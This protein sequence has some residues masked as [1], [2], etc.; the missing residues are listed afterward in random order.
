MTTEHKTGEQP[1]NLVLKARDVHFDWTALPLHW[2]PGEPF[3]THTINVMHLLLPEGE[4]WFVRV[5]QQALPLI[6]DEQLREQVIGFIGQEAV[7]AESHQGAQEH[8]REQ[9]IDP[10][11]YVRQIEWTFHRIL[12]DREL[13]TA[14]QRSW[15][16][17]RLAII[18][19]VE[20][21]TAFLGQWV[22]D[23]HGLDRA[24]ADPTMMDL[25]RWHGAEEVEHRS[26][27]FD[28][29][30]HVNGSYLR[31]LRAMVLVA[32]MLVH[33]WARGVKFLMHADPE[34]RGKVKP[35]WRDGSAAARK[36]LLPSYFSLL[37]KLSTFLSRRYH[38]SQ[39]GSTAQAVAYLATSPAARAAE[40]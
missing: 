1:D 25:L 27:A 2:V 34:L 20:H 26:V 3:T 16:V 40:H 8:L 22:L 23:A 38:P 12:G 24:G 21:V 11:P 39:E 14:A 32:P 35:R 5:F 10:G 37:R 9:G 29:Y 18:A 31:R 13:D 33:I 17:E 6:R 7:H 15:L 30:T 19:A 28:L 36:G 4:R